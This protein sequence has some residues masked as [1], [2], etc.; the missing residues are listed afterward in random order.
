MARKGGYCWRH[1]LF[2]E[3][4]CDEYKIIGPLQMDKFELLYSRRL[5]A[6]YYIDEVE[7]E[8]ADNSFQLA[9]DLVSFFLDNKGIPE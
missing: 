1:D 7:K 4:M 5:K 3:I 6:D 9:S 2:P 8:E